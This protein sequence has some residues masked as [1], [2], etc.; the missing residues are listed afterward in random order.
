MRLGLPAMIHCDAFPDRPVRGTV[1][2]IAAR[3]EFTPRE[4]QTPEERVKT[5]FAVKVRLDENPD[6]RYAPGMP[7]DVVI[8]WK[9]DVPWQAPRW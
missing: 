7:A 4:V 9:D 8:R 3:A 1:G 2:F 6:H 5:V